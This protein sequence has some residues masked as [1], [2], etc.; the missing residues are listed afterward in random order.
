MT[1]EVLCHRCE[2]ELEAGDLRCPV[3]FTGRAADQ[4]APDVAT[5][6]VLRCTDC[7]AVM[8][9]EP[10]QQAAVCPFCAAK[11]ELE[12][13]TDPVEEAQ[14]FVPFAFDQR[15]AV[16]AISEWLGRKRFFAPGDLAERAR[17]KETKA[18]AWAGWVVTAESAVHVTADLSGA[19][20]RAAWGPLVRSFS[21][22]LRGLL[23]PATRGLTLEE[24]A[25][26]RSYDVSTASATPPTGALLEDYGLTRSAA[27]AAIGE[28]VYNDA[29]A[30]LV[31][32]TPGRLRNPRAEVTLSKVRTQRLLLPAYVAAYRYRDKLYRVVVHGQQPGSIVGKTPVSP[33][34]VAGVFAAA[35][36]GLALLA[37]FL[38]R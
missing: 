20:R 1:A 21:R 23:V 32:Q 11:L 28:A 37:F 30:T 34:R 3:C 5:V 8:K 16:G 17:V 9:Y 22:P 27:R 7:A 4:P 25:S 6:K 38:G 14:A 10:S 15:F 31:Q 12:T 33:W 36:L 35:A 2:S 26:L 18:V 29:L 24:V 19:G 13:P